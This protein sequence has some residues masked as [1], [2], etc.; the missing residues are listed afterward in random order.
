MAGSPRRRGSLERRASRKGFTR[1]VYLPVQDFLRTEW[2]GSGI[3][4]GAAIIAL[5]LANSPVGPQ[6]A[7]MW[8]YPLT[9]DLGVVRVSESIRTLVNDGLMALFFFV[10]GLEL[11]RE[12]M[13]GHLS[14]LRSAA[15]PV[16]AALGGMLL[17]AVLYAVMVGGGGEAGRGWG[18]PMA[19]DIAF[20]L[21]ILGV[22]GRA[23]PAQLRIFL[24]TLAVVDDLG[25]ILVVAFAYSGTVSP[26]ALG[27]AT[28]MLAVILLA[29]RF[30]VRSVAAYTVLGFLFWLAVFESGLHATLAGVI[31]AFMTPD[32]HEYDDAEAVALGRELWDR[33]EAAVEKGDHNESEG[34][35]GKVEE[36]V[37]GTEAPLERVERI[38]HPWT[39]YLILPLFALVNAGIPFTGPEAGMTLS[40][41]V[42]AALVVALVGGK[43]AGILGASWIAVKM[44]GAVLPEGVGWGHMAGVAALGGIGF[45]VSLFIVEMAFSDAQLLAAGK[46]GVLLASLL[47][48]ILGYGILKF[49]L[50]GRGS[51][52]AP[53]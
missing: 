49:Q 9:L 1:E 2:V 28:V 14:S 22:F 4:L 41:P 11:K 15:L 3:L 25:A 20:A 52:P 51:R 39:A 19:T 42:A 47:A 46:L 45:T 24:L 44:G 29:Q 30:G 12:V 34:V 48:T 32:Q 40:H 10:V 36:L 23:L 38:I 31:L 26:E 35:L 27:V 53:Q 18:I 21:G 17:P 50:R 16:A 33:Y 13:H 8:E 43:I 6:V 5:I 7:H 37:V